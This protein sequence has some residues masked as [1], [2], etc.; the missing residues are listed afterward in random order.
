MVFWKYIRNQ[1][2]SNED[3]QKELDD[4]LNQSGDTSQDESESRIEDMGQSGDEQQGDEQ[5]QEQ[6]QESEQ[7]QDESQEEKSDGEFQEQNENQGEQSQGDTQ[8]SEQE[9][10]QGDGQSQEQSQESEHGQEE[11]KREQS[12]GEFEDSE[13][14]VGQGDE[15]SQEE[16]QGS[17][18]GQNE[19]Q[20]EQTGIGNQESQQENDGSQ[21]RG[22]TQGSKQEQGGSQE[23]EQPQEQSQGFEQEVSQG[24]QAEEENQSYD[25]RHDD[26]EDTSDSLKSYDESDE[27]MKKLTDLRDKLLQYAAKK[28]EEEQEREKAKL[29]KE[30]LQEASE[31]SI[32]SSE[33][34]YELSE[35][36]NKFLDSLKELPSFKDRS[37]GP[38]YGI[39]TDGYTDV[40][41]SVIRTLITKFL[42]RR[43]CKRNTDLNV[44]SDSLK[45]TKGFYKWEVKDVIT[46]LE[47]EQVTKVLSDKYGYEYANGKNETV[48]LSFYFDMS[49]SM[50]A[51]TNLLAVIA[52]ELLKKGVKVLIG[53]NEKVNVQID[54]IKG[55]ANVEELAKMLEVA[56]YS[57]YNAYSSK[58]KLSTNGMF[59]FKFI[60]EN[61]DN[62]LIKKKAEKCVVFSD[63]DPRY[64]ICNLS[65][66]ADVYWFCFEN[67][68]SKIDVDNFYG[69]IYKVQNEDDIARGLIKVN[70][71]KFE[72]LCFTDNPSEFVKKKV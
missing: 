17:E 2:K 26:E 56:G 67:N 45:K 54:S 46:H 37:R 58:A 48:P 55:N 38:G 5:S 22:D 51:Y 10:S 36:A 9:V 44:R 42:N 47:T 57:T 66:A 40:S 18:Q 60:N 50:S 4:K 30:R 68:F 34:K 61:L 59:K 19:N 27:R 28:L 65:R 39:D 14:E 41:D 49:C 24:E 72:A 70:E 53:F 43:F 32:E 52:I 16:T 8:N 23:D 15:Q 63:F 3:S 69:F 35:H 64:E 12:E 33:E 11:S 62:Y 7:R 25:Q 1:I 20:G 31:E 21:S 71:N 29:E 13:Q 6:T